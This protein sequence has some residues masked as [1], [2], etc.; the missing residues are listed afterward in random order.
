ME[1]EK[2]KRMTESE[3]VT[4][5]KAKTRTVQFD[6]GAGKK[7]SGTPKAKEKA[8]QT[9]E[10]IPIATRASI[11]RAA[12]SPTKKS[13]QQLS[14]KGAGRG[15]TTKGDGPRLTRVQE[16]MK[17]DMAESNQEAF[18]KA[19]GLEK[20][21]PAQL[22]ITKF[23]DK[24][25]LNFIRAW[26]PSRKS[27]LHKGKEV[28]TDLQAVLSI[29]KLSAGG[30]KI[31][32]RVKEWKAKIFEPQTA[33]ED[34]RGYK[35]IHYISR[36]IENRLEFIT[37]TLHMAKPRAKYPRYMVKLAEQWQKGEK[38]WASFFY[39]SFIGTMNQATRAVKK[40]ED[41]EIELGMHI[42]LLLAGQAQLP[43]LPVPK[44]LKALKPI[45]VELLLDDSLEEEEG[46]RGMTAVSKSS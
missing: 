23:M 45:T 30:E 24:E 12:K 4:P 10:E 22:G 39:G 38:D 46:A 29:F 28:R 42:R 5:K 41:L 6:D 9:V 2:Q 20:F 11:S 37:H 16:G 21:E 15:I 27:Q 31:N 17:E 8:G 34:E 7:K 19:Q 33:D 43:P 26:S 18:L 44:K 35:V 36:W 3:E 32:Q 25:V 1:M 40:K 13:I 14:K